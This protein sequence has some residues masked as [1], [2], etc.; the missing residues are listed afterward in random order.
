[1]KGYSETA[2]DLF[3]RVKCR[4]FVWNWID[5]SNSS[6]VNG[7]KKEEVF[8]IGDFVEVQCYHTPDIA[9]GVM[10][11]IMQYYHFNPNGIVIHVSIADSLHKSIIHSKITLN[12][13]LLTANNEG[14]FKCITCGSLLQLM[15]ILTL[16]NSL[17]G[18][19]CLILFEGLNPLLI[20]QKQLNGSVNSLILNDFYRCISRLKT[21]QSV[22]C[23][24]FSSALP[25]NLGGL[26]EGT[27]KDQLS[28]QWREK[29]PKSFYYCS[30]PL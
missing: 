20:E 12:Q 25:K 23:L 27:V 5:Y 4:Q 29:V 13:Q 19:E 3:K 7:E 9:G 11:V 14:R 16:C 18:K 17:D 1:M 22:Y 15:A 2:S 30:K 6:N 8:N 26:R 10:D 21:Y 24:W 28:T